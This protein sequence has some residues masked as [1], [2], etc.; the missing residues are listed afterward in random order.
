MEFG[1]WQPWRNP[2]LFLLVWQKR[3]PGRQVNKS[4]VTRNWHSLDLRAFLAVDL[5]LADLGLE[6]VARLALSII[7]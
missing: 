2:G 3:V 6:T 5:G 7:L 4:Q 1:L